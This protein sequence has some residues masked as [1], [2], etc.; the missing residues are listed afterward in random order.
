MKKIILLIFILESCYADAQ[1][2]SDFQKALRTYG[3]AV[4]AIH[5]YP[6]D[7]ENGQ[8]HYVPVTSIT[9]AGNTITIVET[10]TN[11]YSGKSRT[12]LT[13]KINNEAVEGTWS[14]DYS[15]GLWSYNFKTNSG[16]W[17]KTRSMLGTFENWQN[18]RFLILDQRQLR[19]GPYKCE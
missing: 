8:C 14:S 3:K 16:K 18:L 19:D 1:S 2:F 13:G 11:G 12:V 6:P 9:A 15:G 17:N 4:Q 10:W 5:A 7:I